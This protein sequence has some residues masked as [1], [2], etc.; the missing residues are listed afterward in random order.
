MPVIKLRSSSPETTEIS[1]SKL[2]RS[3]HSFIIN[4]FTMRL[5]F[6]SFFL[7]FISLSL[8]S[9]LDQTVMNNDDYVPERMVHPSLADLLTIES[10]ASI[11]YSYARELELSKM[12]SN[13]ELN[14]TL[15]AP[16]NK[17]VMALARKPCVDIIVMYYNPSSNG[18]CR[19]EGN[20][21][22]DEGIEITEEEFDTLSKSNVE[23][24]VSAHII[25]V[26]LAT[27]RSFDSSFLL[28]W[29]QESPI[30]LVSES[31]KTLLEGKSVKFT[32]IGKVDTHNPDWR[33]VTLEDGVRI[34]GKRE[35]RVFRSLSQCH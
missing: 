3:S 23:R 33:Q 12:F 16:N 26:C 6:I 1:D 27:S 13:T 30:S 18:H 24:W 4:I 29:T 22:V 14:I 31:Y 17:A 15:L 35:V 7:P 21:P 10:S 19:H 25:T 32:P 20:T 34:V 28:S 11:F 9:Q 8:A 2:S 5:Q